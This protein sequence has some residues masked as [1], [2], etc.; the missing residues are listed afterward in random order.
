M[1]EVNEK[2]DRALAFFAGLGWHLLRINGRRCFVTVRDL[3]V[4]VLTIEQAV[5]GLREVLEGN[6]AWRV[7]RPAFLVN[8]E[9]YV[10][11][12]PRNED[13]VVPT[14]ERRWTYLCSD[15][16]GRNDHHF[17]LSSLVE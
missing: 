15:Y 5:E 1:G 9:K 6:F 11:T 3:E 13:R 12:L 17:A 8:G 4:E 2:L 7:R 16:V 10:F 14:A